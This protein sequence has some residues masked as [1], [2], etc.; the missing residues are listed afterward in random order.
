MMLMF[1]FCNAAHSAGSDFSREWSL[2]GPWQTAL[3]S[4][5]GMLGPP[6]LAWLHQEPA[7]LLERTRKPVGS[8]SGRSQVVSPAC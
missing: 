5:A 1:P 7:G 4:Q 3:R 2:P 8:Q 6:C